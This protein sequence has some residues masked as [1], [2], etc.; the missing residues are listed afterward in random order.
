MTVVSIN[1]DPD[2]SSMRQLTN[3]PSTLRAAM[4][5]LLAVALSAGVTAGLTAQAS[6]T[7]ALD[8]SFGGSLVGT[9][10]YTTQGD[11]AQRGSLHRI[12]GAEEQV[13][14]GVKLRGGT[15]GLRFDAAALHLG[16]GSQSFVM[17]TVFTPTANPT[18]TTYLSPEE[19]SS[20]APRTA[21]FATA[22]RPTRPAPG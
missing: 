1:A 13:P 22:T 3:R 17:E 5:G 2:G 11:E 19:T 7:D 4:I 14:E 9:T 10:Q 8:V 16:T 20:S 6:P 12:S 15:Q 18:L 21:S